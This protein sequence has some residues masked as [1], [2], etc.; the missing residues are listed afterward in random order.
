MGRIN[1][2]GFATLLRRELRRYKR[3][4]WETVGAPAFS[5]LVYFIVFALALGERRGAPEGEAILSFLAPGLVMMSVLMRAAETTSYSLMLDKMEGIIS[6]ILGAPISAAEMTAAYALSGAA[7]SLVTGSVTA[8]ALMLVWPTVPAH[9]WAVGLFGV[10]GAL[11]LSLWGILV[12]LWG[13]KWDQLAAAFV[14]FLVPLIFLS[15]LF[16]PV[17]TLPSPLAAAMRLNP[18]FHAIDGFRFGFIGTSDQ[19]P[20]LSAGVVAGTCALLWP[21]CGTLIRRG[22]KLRP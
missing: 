16:V 13:E 14:F 20:L 21:L 10:L 12:G 6:D 22:Y 18:V 3:E 17:D 15:G 11:M 5:A 19:P 8:A 7:A 4:A 2:L 9:P 1:W